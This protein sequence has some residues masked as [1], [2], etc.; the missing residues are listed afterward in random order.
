MTYS[1]KRYWLAMAGALALAA[2]TD[3]LLIWRRPAHI[4]LWSMA[5]VAVVFALGLLAY[6]SQ[7]EIQHQNSMRAWYWGGCLAIV[8]GVVPFIL[9][10]SNAMLLM[11]VDFIPHP[12]RAPQAVSHAPKVY[13]V[14]GAMVVLLAQFVG[15]FLARI[16]LRFRS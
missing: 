1:R 10:S 15:F 6:F 4:G 8:L 5:A 16:M 7:D 11:M 13:F 14:M 12:G 2:A 9:I 3:A